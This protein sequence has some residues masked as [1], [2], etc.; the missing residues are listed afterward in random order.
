MTAPKLFAESDKI[1]MGNYSNF[2]VWG[3]E[4]PLI[5]IGLER[6]ELGKPHFFCF[7]S[8]EIGIE[9]HTRPR[10][11][12]GSKYFATDF[13]RSTGFGGAEMLESGFI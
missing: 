6:M 5:K 4:Y 1:T 11:Q 7:P 12:L 13:N 10:C 8:I 9:Q 3:R 2:Y